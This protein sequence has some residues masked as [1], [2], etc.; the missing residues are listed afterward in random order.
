[1]Q[2]NTREPQ[3]YE[4]LHWPWSTMAPLV[5][6]AAREISMEEAERR[7]L[8]LTH[9]AFPGTVFS[10]PN[11]SGGIQVLEPGES[12]GSHRHTLAALRLVME[13]EGAVTVVDGKRCVM[14]PGDL[15]LT[16]GWSWH[17]HRHEGKTRMV[18]F[19]GLDYPLA[20]Q[21]GTV[22]FEMG[23]GPVPDHGLANLED[24]ALREGG[25][26]PDGGANGGDANGGAAPPYSPLYR[27]A[28]SR[29][30]DVLEAMPADADGCRR[31]RYINPADGGPVMPTLD[32]YALR[33]TPGM[34]T[35]AFRTTSNAMAVVIEGEGETR[36]GDRHF[37]WSRN[38]V[39]TL[40]RWQWIEHKATRG[41]ATLFLMTD[42]AFI[43]S[44]GQ[45]REETGR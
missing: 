31:V 28:W 18:W 6:R 5:D 23:P 1:M 19:D 9:P 36:I 14:E 26:L 16:P 2:L 35:T 30:R 37:T 22:F 10:T 27:Y 38:D 45:L 15:V 8:L 3:Y 33:L 42:R 25:V 20:R 41:P 21:L 4:P 17:E 39:F 7:V 24:A 34:T 29:V 12:A 11:L 32:C 44:I 13:G 43:A 40:P